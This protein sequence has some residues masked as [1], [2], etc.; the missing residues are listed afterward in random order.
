MEKRA[1]VVKFGQYTQYDAEGRAHVFR[2]GDLI[3]LTDED[4]A[5]HPG[6]F[7]SLEASTA[8]DVTANADDEDDELGER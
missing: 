5:G 3:E 7:D 2:E 4:A 1:Y 6:A 8:P